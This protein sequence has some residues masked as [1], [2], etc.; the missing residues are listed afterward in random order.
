M[1]VWR[2]L[3]PAVIVAGLLLTVGGCGSRLPTTFQGMQDQSPSVDAASSRG[4][5]ESDAGAST[6][7]DAGVGHPGQPVE[8]DAGVP[9]GMATD[10]A[11]R[12]AD[13]GSTDAGGPE[14]PPYPPA[15]C[16]D[17]S[18]VPAVPGHAT[19]QSCGGQLALSATLTTN[20][21]TAPHFFRCGTLGP[22]I[23]TDLQLSPDGARLATLTGAGT[24]RLFA[25]DDWHEIAQLGPVSGRID[26]FAFSPDGARVATLSMER[27]ELTVWNAADGTTQMTFTGPA[28]AGGIPFAKATLAFS[29]DGR[30]IASSLGTIVD[31]G[32]RTVVTLGQW[33]LSGFVDQMAF[34]MCDAMLYVRSGYRTGDSNW[35]TEV[36][37]YD[38]QTG[39]VKTL[40]NLWGSYFGGSAL[41]RD[42]RLLA[43]SNSYHPGGAETNDLSIYRGDTG[44]LVDY[45][46]V[47]LPGTI[48]TFTP[49]D[50]ALLVANNGTL[51]QWRIA[52][53]SVVTSYWFGTGAR[54][55]G[56]PRPDAVTISAPTDTTS[57]SLRQNYTVI[58]S[59]WF[60]ATAAS[61]TA[62]GSVA[63]ALVADGTLFHVW[64]EP[65]ATEMCTPAAPGPTAA[66]TS[67]GL[68]GDGRVLGV[69]KADGV[70]DLFETATGS[71]R[72]GI[73]TL[74][75]PV[76]GM[77]LSWDGTAVAARTSASDG[78]VQI[79]S[80]G[81]GLVGS[82]T[83]PAH[84]VAPYSSMPF[85]LSPDARTVALGDGHT[86]ATLINVATGTG[87]P[88]QP[89]DPWPVGAAFSPDS[90]HLAAWSSGALATWRV[91]DGVRDDVLVAPVDIEPAAGAI[92]PRIALASDW[93]LAAALN[94]TALVVWD[95]HDGAE[96]SKT[97]VSASGYANTV[98]GVARATVAVN[99]Y[100]VHTFAADYYV[101]HLYDVPSGVE[102]RAFGAYGGVRPLLLGA[103][104]THAYT[105]E[106]PDVI[107]W[108][109]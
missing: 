75:G 1:E 57:W 53:G 4:G 9:T 24:V 33:G 19:V 88:V 99:E 86:S 22:E 93:S 27:G 38:T 52:D 76:A 31:L 92:A 48:Q 83:L 43:V 60:S 78:P 55:L 109:R 30:R 28:T 97:A 104:G 32:R 25:T 90:L 64:R 59:L 44:Q 40:F 45:R 7:R 67:F 17:A 107:V 80:A 106:P 79:W 10:A 41:S 71:R 46:P 26:A 58:A 2:G 5:P 56:F 101:A 84:T 81:G 61:W 3:S 16:S 69:G 82:V 89:V 13:A 73:E 102:L 20:G 35:S 34:T 42:G 11:S 91:A 103:D 74:Q 70:V 51:D 12:A 23:E 65:D 108:C 100:L 54:L 49:D 85:A 15:T 29:R 72:S 63:A 68:S 6:D 37:L 95:P 8:L 21:S 47:W 14:L 77:A 94:G 66:A 96:L 18:W 87:Q 62:D 36:S 98:L 39:A 105:L 50:T